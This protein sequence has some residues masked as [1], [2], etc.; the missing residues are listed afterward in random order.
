MTKVSSGVSENN[1]AS[2]YHRTGDTE[3]LILELHKRFLINTNVY[4]V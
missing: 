3:L 2:G 4:V 1:Y